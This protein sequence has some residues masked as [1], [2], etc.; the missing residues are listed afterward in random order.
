V[1]GDGRNVTGQ[2][3]TH[4]LG[5]IAEKYGIVGGL[6]G[7]M[8]GTTRRRS[9]HDR[10]TVLTQL[11][12]MIVGSWSV[13]LSPWVSP[14]GSCHASTIPGA[15]IRMRPPTPLRA[16]DRWPNAAW[17][18]RGEAWAVEVSTWPQARPYQHLPDIMNVD[19]AEALSHRAISGFLDRVSRST[20]RFDEAFLRDCKGHLELTR[21]PA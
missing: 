11:A 14:T 3:G 21:P 5:R 19:N 6:S 7:A 16:G 1:T 13:T 10:G 4:L 12:M 17:G 20:L 15:S 9:A 8:A 18:R 2:A